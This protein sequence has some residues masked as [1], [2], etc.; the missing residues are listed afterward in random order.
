[1]TRRTAG[2]VIAALAMGAVLAACSS[3]PSDVV[4]TPT[5][6]PSTS[7]TPASSTSSTSSASGPKGN[8]TAV[9]SPNTGLRDRQIVRVTADGFTPA[10]QLQ[11]VQCADKGTATGPGDCNLEGMTPVTADATGRVVTQVRVL[12]GP[13]GGNKIVCSAK[14]KCL[15][16]ITQLSLTP[17][18]EADGAISFAAA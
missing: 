11:V 6:A 10:E 14:Q 4:R 5:V 17:T 7:S 9:V 12:R 13:F 8:P 15:V 2:P 1:M 18:E 16:S 3:S